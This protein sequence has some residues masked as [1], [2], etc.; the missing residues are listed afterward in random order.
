MTA[1]T[2]YL[3]IF[4]AAVDSLSIESR[5]GGGRRSSERRLLLRTVRPMKP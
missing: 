3:L 1:M 4:A 5:H 2:A